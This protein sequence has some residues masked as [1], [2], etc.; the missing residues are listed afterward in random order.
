VDAPTA[1]ERASWAARLGDQDLHR[2]LLAELTCLH[3]L[4]YAPGPD[5]D[6]DPGPT[7]STR[8]A[9]LHGW[10]RVAA[11]NAERGR[12]VPGAA[13]LLRR[14]RADLLLLS[15]LD[16]G[17]ARSGNVDVP[18]TLAELL[19]TGYGFAVEFIELSG[20]NERGLHGNAILT[21]AP[22]EHAGVVRL[23]GEGSWFAADTTE[24]RVGGRMGVVGT[25]E[26]DGTPV[27]VASTHLENMTDPDGRA[28]Q[29]DTLLDAVG[30][31]P[32]PAVVGG[33][34][35][36]F[37]A[38]LERLADRAAVRHMRTGDPTRF[39]WPVDYEPLFD[40][41]RSHGFAWIEANVAGP[42][43]SH[44]AL[45]LPDHVPLKLDWILVRGLEAR[46]PAVTSC[47]GL[48]DHQVVSVA[49]RLPN[50][51]P[52]PGPVP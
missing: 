48:S 35:N 31:A 44:D 9:S 16:S 13:G 29:L 38:P 51:G 37:G 8:A 33:D 46:R 27:R 1:M 17:M 22:L 15:E 23:G 30:P 4:E 2:R 41:A 20:D 34:L 50:P 18:R 19:G 14:C 11:W 26:V 10:V 39:S 25:V 40:V 42:T 12:D 52:D 36:T 21:A 5:P 43:T 6:P 49:I 7:P 24:P 47:D 45:G 32:A 3:E 28:A